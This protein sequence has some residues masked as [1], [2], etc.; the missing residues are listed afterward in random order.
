[1]KKALLFSTAILLVGALQSCEKDT[2]TTIEFPNKD[3]ITSGVW[4]RIDLI[5]NGESEWGDFLSCE[6]DDEWCFKADNS[7]LLDEGA[8]KCDLSD[9]QTVFGQWTMVNNTSID[10]NGFLFT[11]DSINSTNMVLT[12]DLLGSK[13]SSYF[14]KK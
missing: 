8:L 1:M 11:I 13:A 6:R 3:L 7:L 14:K 10:L 9:P 12:V 4:I 2:E 5:Q